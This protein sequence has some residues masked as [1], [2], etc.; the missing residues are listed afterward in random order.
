MPHFKAPDQSLH[1]LSDADIS[2]GGESMLPSGCI[3]ITDAEAERIRLAEQV[4]APTV[5][6]SE[7]PEQ[8]L[9]AFL[10]A[11]PDVLALVESK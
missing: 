4:V 9:A 1:F 3:Q 5:T 11:N 7:T 6:P 8:K 10:A 2:N